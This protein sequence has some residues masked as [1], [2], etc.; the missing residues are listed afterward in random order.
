MH[1]NTNFQRAVNQDTFL[2]PL[3]EGRSLQTRHAGDLAQRTREVNVT[4]LLPLIRQH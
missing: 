3:D 2:S 4:E 1:V